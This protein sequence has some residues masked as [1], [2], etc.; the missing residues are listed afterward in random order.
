MAG[1]LK[2]L[3][4]SPYGTFIVLATDAS[5]KDSNDTDTVNRI[6]SLIDSMQAKVFVL[7]ANP[8]GSAYDYDF[9]VYKDIA[10]HSYGHVFQN[11]Y[12]STKVADLL[13]FFLQI[14]LNSTT[15]LF[16]VDG[17]SYYYANFSISTYFT[18][19]IISTACSSCLVTIHNP[20]GV[21]ANT[22]IILSESWGSLF[23]VENPD[24][25]RWTLNVYAGS[26]YS[27]RILGFQAICS[28]C[29][30]KSTCKK[31]L[32]SYRCVCNEGFSGDGYSCYDINE[33]D[34]NYN[35]TNPCSNGYCINTYGSYNCV[36]SSGYILENK[37]CVDVD[38]CSRTELNSC[39]PLAT[40]Y[41][42]NGSYSCSCPA[43][44][45]GNGYY[46][47]VVNCSKDVCGFDI[48]CT[49]YNGSLSCLD[50]CY[51]Y[52]TLNEPS[53]STS[54]FVYY[55]YNYYYYYYGSNDYYLNGWF[56]FVGS[57]GIR[58]P[59]FCPSTGSCFTR[60]PL[61]LNGA[62][63]EPT[64]GIVNR[65]VCAL[66][67]GYC[68]Y[69][70]SI[71]QI[72][73]CPGG[74]HVYKFNGNPTNY[75]RYC[76]DP[77]T[78][79]DS[80]L[81]ADD[82]E[83]K[84]V[85]GRYGCYCKYTTDISALQDIRPEISCGYPEIK[86]S[87]LKCNLQKFNLSTTNI[88][89][90][91]KSCIGFPDFNM[92]NIISVVSILKKEVC[93]NEI[94]IAGPKGKCR[95]YDN[96]INNIHPL[97]C[98][99]IVGEGLHQDACVVNITIN[100]SGQLLASI[101]LYQD[102]SYKT[103]YEGPEILLT[104]ETVLYVGIILQS[105]ASDQYSVLMKNCYATSSM[106]SSSSTKYDIIKD[107]CPSNLD[108]TINVI[109]NGNSQ[110]GR[111]S[112]QLFGYVKDSNVVYLHCEIHICENATEICTPFNIGRSL[113]SSCTGVFQ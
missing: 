20:S 112:V 91:D 13:N 32:L 11:V 36:C 25:G 109:E 53:R 97:T 12:P 29:D 113:E 59:E 40:C 106:N 75:S 95:G 47:E 98:I 67:S 92:T 56:R 73:A 61:W 65:T 44:Y 80:C 85:G 83:C 26:S 7:G 105:V 23:Y 28:T 107:S 104:S 14:P 76:T 52:T 111:F 49:T 89:L 21:Q 60:Y 78:F 30:I 34:F 37:T 51:T 96:M 62:H 15:R 94:L 93:G 101:A 55:Y 50:P 58:M 84:L 46:C 110:N 27:L 1:L 24:T 69:W 6:F 68:C 81:C 38:E 18:S 9:Q 88:H 16:S 17:D 33:C 82:E 42:Y 108:S 86:A 22:S 77:T 87:F 4:N 90:R 54:Y 66:Y 71:V 45:L 19:L 43:G 48:E 39:H 2:A 31:D 64:N 63:P 3:E 35:W 99:F 74:Y 57:G 103:P 10:S 102:S 100:S 5:A 70:T 72:K 79:A 41:N 8:C